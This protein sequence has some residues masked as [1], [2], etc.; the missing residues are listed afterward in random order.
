M[1]TLIDEIKS[2][3]HDADLAALASEIKD[4]LNA[5]R[6]T[7]TTTD[8]MVGDKIIFNDYAG[9]KY[10]VGHTGV[11]VGK[12]KTKVVVSLDNPVGRF[13]VNRNGKVESA[14]ITVPVSIID[15]A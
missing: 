1:S 11:V 4:R 10:I 2:G 13:A 15:K 7:R 8:F 5:V 12:K 14:H 6:S 9:T 3:K